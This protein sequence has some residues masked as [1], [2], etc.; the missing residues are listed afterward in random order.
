MSMKHTQLTDDLQERASLYA[1]GA[2]TDSER[3]E[4]V[5]HLEEDD[6]LVCQAEVKE[7][8]SAISLLA[9]TVP[10]S[11]PSPRVKTRLLE[12]ARAAAPIVMKPRRVLGWV[13]WITA[14]VAVASM[15]VAFVLLRRNTE[16]RHES[17]LLRS[18]VAQLE[19]EVAGQRSTIA[20]LTSA[21]RVIDLA[22]QG[23]HVQA[24]ARIFVKEQQRRWLMYV[25]NLPPSAADK[26]Y[27]LWF[28]P[29]A[30]NPVKAGVFRTDANG[31]AAVEIDIPDNLSALKAAAVTTEPAPGVDQPTGSFALLGAL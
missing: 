28:V 17:D 19:V 31:S 9:F 3:L 20:A 22:G 14:A 27:E 13:E 6:C 30:G 18:R 8:Q 11:T 16:L 29:R 25:R 1:A 24:S 2:M 10:S 15:A 5:R 23:T 7:L 21:E 26:V 12:Q 4:Y